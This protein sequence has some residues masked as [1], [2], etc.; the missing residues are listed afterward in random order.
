V[1]VARTKTNVGRLHHAMRRLG[2]RE[3]L[4]ERRNRASLD[5]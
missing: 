1:I 4:S 2:S 5:T 3:I